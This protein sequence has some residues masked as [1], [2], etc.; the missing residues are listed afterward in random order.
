MSRGSVFENNEDSLHRYDANH[1]QAHYH[2]G[3]VIQTNQSH[4]QYEAS[5]LTEFDHRYT[6]SAAVLLY[7]LIVN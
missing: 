6:V 3:T 1:K 2:T 7:C 4:M 5:R